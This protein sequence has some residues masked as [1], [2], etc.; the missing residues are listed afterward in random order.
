MPNYTIYKL[1]NFT[2]CNLVQII[3]LLCSCWRKKLVLKL[4]SGQFTP[5]FSKS[6]TEFAMSCPKFSKS[7]P[8]LAMSCPMFSKS[9]TEFAMSCPTFSKSF[10]EFAM[11]CPPENTWTHLKIFV[12]HL[13]IFIVHLGFSTPAFRTLE[14][15]YCTPAF[16]HLKRKTPFVHLGFYVHPNFLKTAK[17]EYSPLLLLFWCHCCPSIMTFSVK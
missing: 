6:F 7:F 14:N 2:L 17:T 4:K 16:V 5:T 12:V 8:E 11:S 15:I 3:L 1:H 13:K 10:T 9:F